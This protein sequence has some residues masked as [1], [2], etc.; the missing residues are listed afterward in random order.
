[1]KLPCKTL[2]GFDKHFTLKT[3]PRSKASGLHKKARELMIEISPRVLIY[4]E[5]IV[6]ILKNKKLTFDF[7]VYTDNAFI[8]VQ[9]EQHF[10]YSPFFHK[11]KTD[12]LMGQKR[13]RD[14]EYWCELNNY[15]LITLRFDETIEQWKSKL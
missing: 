2:D 1:M 10:K 5:V 12:F 9:G 7:F 8:E 3:N 15:K 13:D 14:K 4:E 11:S 6:P